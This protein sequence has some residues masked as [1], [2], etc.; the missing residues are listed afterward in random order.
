MT[1]RISF[2]DDFKRRA[3]SIS[4]EKPFSAYPD[5]K[6]DTPVGQTNQTRAS[7]AAQAISSQ[8]IFNI[9]PREQNYRLIVDSI[10]GF[11]CTL[12]ATVEIEYPNHQVLEL[13]R[14]KYTALGPIRCAASL[15]H[16]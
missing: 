9:R 7:D 2:P 11:V 8:T 5:A 6:V 1:A 16:F 15:I 10:P 14:D 3:E 13:A 4:R 12:T